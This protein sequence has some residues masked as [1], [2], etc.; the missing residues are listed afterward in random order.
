M[1][2]PTVSVL[3]T[4]WNRENFIRESIESVLDSTFKD[5]ELIIVDDKSSD[6][7]IEIAKEYEKKDSRVKIHKNTVNI[8]DY[9][10]RNKAASLAIGKYIKY[11]DADDIIYRHGLEVMVDS[12]ERYPSAGLALSVKNKTSTP[13]P[14]L[15]SSRE[16]YREHY[17]GNGLFNNS[18]L[19]AIIRRSAFLSVGGFSGKRFVGD[20]ELWFKIAE[21]FPI[22]NMQTDLTWWRSHPDQE[23]K[24][25]NDDGQQIKIRNE[26]QLSHIRNTINLSKAEKST[27]INLLKKR[28]IANAVQGLV[29]YRSFT[30]TKNH[31][32]S[33]FL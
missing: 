15:V 9:P 27:A 16:A 11:V 1:K 17:L 8:G 30:Y 32:Y 5:F 12:L 24:K 13:F 29:K 18:P 6:N 25:E 19:S 21:I 7:S 14:T 26:L 22:V 20:T 23:S 4:V 10:N 3:M 2:N 31:F 28:L 33:L